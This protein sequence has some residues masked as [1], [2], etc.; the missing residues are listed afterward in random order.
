VEGV[1]SMRK[2]YGAHTPDNTSYVGKEDEIVVR[3]G[4]IFIHDGSTPG[5]V[6][7]TSGSGESSSAVVPTVN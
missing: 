7:F 5:G 2:I 6:E 1:L 3:N 4:G